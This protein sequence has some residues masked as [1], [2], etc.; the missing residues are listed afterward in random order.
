MPRRKCRLSSVALKAP[1]DWCQIINLLFP[2]MNPNVLFIITPFTFL[3]FALFALFST[4]V[5][6][7]LFPCSF[8]AYW[9][10][11][12]AHAWRSSSFLKH[13][14]SFSGRWTS[15]FPS[16]LPT[17]CLLISTSLSGSPPLLLARALLFENRHHIVLTM[18]DK[19]HVVSAN[20]ANLINP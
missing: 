4:S 6:C 7:S 16:S 13:S 3:P 19:E 1:H 15:L 5:F 8:L 17:M 10:P 14:L 20:T 11:T 9:N 18:P 2:P 12:P